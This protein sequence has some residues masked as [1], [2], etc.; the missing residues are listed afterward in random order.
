MAPDR[1]IHMGIGFATGRTIFLSVLKAYIFHIQETN[2]L[3]RCNLRLSLY[4]AYDPTYQ[5]TRREDYDQLTAEEREV[6]SQ[7][8]FLGPE[9]IDA[10]LDQLV[11][12]GSLPPEQVGKL[13]KAGG[14]GERLLEAHLHNLGSEVAQGGVSTAVLA[15]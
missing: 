15:A 11:E 13:V 2:L 12:D 5:N 14:L 6:F 4:I 7:C 8:K 9:D 3:S 10:V 1:Q